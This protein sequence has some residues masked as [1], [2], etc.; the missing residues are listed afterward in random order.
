MIIDHF[1]E[2]K[3]N[4]ICD[5]KSNQMPETDQITEI[6]LYHPFFELSITEKFIVLYNFQLNFD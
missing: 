2:R 3:K 5:Q 6:I 4:P 1:E